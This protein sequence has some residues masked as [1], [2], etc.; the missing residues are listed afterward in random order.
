MTDLRLQRQSC[1]RWNR[2]CSDHHRAPLHQILG[3]IRILDDSR[4]RATPRN[5]PPLAI[6]GESRD[7]ETAAIKGA[8]KFIDGGAP[9]A[10]GDVDVG[11][12]PITTN[13]TPT[14]GNAW[15][16]RDSG[17]HPLE[18]FLGP[19]QVRNSRVPDARGSNWS[20]ERSVSA[21]TDT[22]T[23]GSPVVIMLSVLAPTRSLRRVRLLLPASSSRLVSRCSRSPSKRIT[24]AL[25]QLR[26]SPPKRYG[27]VQLFESKESCY[28]NTRCFRR[29]LTASRQCLVNAMLFMEFELGGKLDWLA[30]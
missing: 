14:V 16:P 11:G 22:I 13:S 9:S 8:R 10:V 4:R 26:E 17:F 20:R 3:S 2:L 1:I 19:N 5:P 27:Q 18:V 6:N 21:C 23:A 25:F 7:R 24:F 15:N 12:F 30:Q 29:L 28:P